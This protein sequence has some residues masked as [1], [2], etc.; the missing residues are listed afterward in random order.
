MPLQ[1]LFAHWVWAAPL[2][3]ALLVILGFIGSAPAL[4]FGIGLIGAVL[5]AVHHAEVI[6]H[7]VG[8]PFGTFLLAIA[9]TVI[10]L[11]LIL[12]LMAQANTGGE[13]LARDTVIAAV[14]IIVNGLMGLCILIGAIKHHE[15]EFQQTG[16]SASLAAL[17][18]LTVLTLVLPNFTVSGHGP[19][20]STSQLAFVAVVSFLLYATFVSAQTVR[21]RDYFLPPEGAADPEVHAPAPSNGQ[22]LASAGL[23]VACLI[24]WCC[25]PSCSRRRSRP[26]WRRRVRRAPWSA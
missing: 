19:F 2:L 18:A 15:Q 21:H 23:L 7:R 16:V 3:A 22:T 26:R 11:G 6:A 14:M 8:E 12:T 20:Y 1:R 25:S 4:L 13:T 5:A 9:V 10:E 24:T 17:S